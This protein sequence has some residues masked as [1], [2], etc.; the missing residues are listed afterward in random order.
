MA[1]TCSVTVI[2]PS[3]AAMPE[4]MRAPTVSAVST[5]ASSR[6]SVSTTTRPTVYCT[7]KRAR[8]KPNCSEMTSPAKV[9]VSRAMGRERT[10]KDSVW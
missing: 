10:P 6:N 5:G 1:S 7:P 4:P 3:S 2:A 8:K 9:E